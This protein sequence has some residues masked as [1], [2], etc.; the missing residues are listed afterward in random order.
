MNDLVQVIN[1]IEKNLDYEIDYN[2]LCK[3]LSLTNS[4][5]QRI[6]PVI[7]NM[8]TSEYIRKRRLSKA[9]FDLQHSKFSVLE[10][11]LK[12]GY[13]THEAFTTAFKKFHENTPSAV[14]K[15]ASFRFIDKL[16]LSITIQGG[17]EL[18]LEI[19]T[20]PDF[21]VA[22]LS[23]NTSA[24]SPEISKL[25]RQLTESNLVN[26]LIKVSTGNSFGVSYGIN[27][28]GTLTYMAGWEIKNPELVNHLP[29][30]VTLIPSTTFAIIPCFGRFPESLYHAW[31]YILNK[32]LPESGY[33]Y[34]GKF[35]LE[36]YPN[37]FTDDTNFPMQLW[38]PIEKINL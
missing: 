17:K 23:I 29:L 35:D 37:K 2:Q 32:F 6:F 38:I 1:R 19:I 8:T 15:G 16:E 3:G 34:I 5:L 26:K 30:Q 4:T 22:G 36:Y 31:N 27:N 21:Y 24:N 10:I 33:T 7:F 18:P 13:E 12:Y 20:L 25:W 14:R 11:A 28:N 9:A